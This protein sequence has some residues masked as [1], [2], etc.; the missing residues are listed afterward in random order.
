MRSEG[1]H[2]TRSVFVG[3]ADSPT[4]DLRA[5]AQPHPVL[6]TPPFS[7]KRISFENSLIF[8]IKGVSMAGSKKESRKDSIVRTMASRESAW[9]KVYDLVRQIPFGRVMTYGQISHY[10][11]P[12]SAR[13]VG[14]AMHNC[15][16]GV[17]WHRVV[18]SRG[19]CS[20]D[21]LPHLPTGLQRALLEQE[22]VVFRD[23]G[24]LSLSEYLWD[25]PASE[26]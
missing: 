13:A 7:V 12:L 15:P 1:G 5:P 25:P 11:E 26:M 22:G 2:L 24:T 4:G 8:L 9:Q 18:N 10:T 16:D 23:N 20:T 3:S 21:R 17:P 19:G 6:R 14:W